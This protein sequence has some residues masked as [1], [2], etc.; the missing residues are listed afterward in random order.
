MS[1]RPDLRVTQAGQQ[2]DDVVHHELVVEDTVL[3]LTHQHRDKITEIL[4]E[5]LV[6]RAVDNQRIVATLL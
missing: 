3:T 1:E 6:E 5:L 4:T 2:G